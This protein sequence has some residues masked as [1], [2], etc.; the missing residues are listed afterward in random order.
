[1]AGQERL[2][3]AGR[4]KLEAGMKSVRRLVILVLGT[5]GVLAAFAS[6]A[7]AISQIPSNHCEPLATPTRIYDIG[8]K[9]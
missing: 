6:A 1:M 9:T 4:P 8:G 2:G 7:H 5:T 3:V